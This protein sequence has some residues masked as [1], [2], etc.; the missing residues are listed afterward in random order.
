MVVLK[1]RSRLVSFRMSDE[2]YQRLC[3]ICVAVGARSI[4]DLARTAVG[5][6]IDTRSD[7]GD[8]PVLGQMRSLGRTIQQ[9]QSKVDQ[10]SNRL[11]DAEKAMR[12]EAEL[13]S[14]C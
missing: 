4:S 13:S 11:T 14:Q 10:L 2:E 5:R 6:L 9:L 3:S 8:D 7:Y 12:S 1:K